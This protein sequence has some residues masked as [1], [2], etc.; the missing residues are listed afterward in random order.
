MAALRTLLARG[1]GV[2]AADLREDRRLRYLLVGATL[3]C[4]FW[5]WHR[6]PN[7][8]TRDEHSRLLDV[9][10]AYG[11]VAADPSVESLQQGVAWGRV[12]FGATFYLFGLAVLPV[13][14]LAVLLGQGELLTVFASP[15]PE[16]G[17]YPSWAATPG[18]FWTGALVVVR[19]VNVFLAVGC[20]YLTYRVGRVVW[21]R[22]AG[23]L[24]GLLLTLTF[25][26]LTIAHEGGEDM[27]ALC[28]VLLALY[29]LVRYVQAGARW[30]FLAASTAGGVAIAFKL[31]AAPVVALVLAAHVLRARQ[32]RDTWA[33]LARPALLLPGA[34]L[35]AVAIALGFP[36][37]LVGG[38]EEVVWRI[39]VNPGARATQPTGPDAAVWWWFLRGYLSGMSL[40]L[41]LGAVAGVVATLLRVRRREAAAGTVLVLTALVLWVGLFAGWHD[42]RV[43]HLLPTFPLLALLL[44][45]ALVRFH[46]SR[47]SLARPAVAVLLVTAGLY[48]AVGVGGYA[49]MPRDDAVAWLEANAE[50]GDTVEVYRRH[51]QDTAVPHGMDVNHLYGWEGAAEAVDRCPEFIQL[52]YRDLLYLDPG[53]Y[54]R[55]GDARASYIEGLVSE[56]YNYER[57]AEFGT[58]PPGFVPQRPTPGSVVDLLRHGVVPQTDQ[59]ADEQELAANQ[60]T[61][62]LERTGDCDGSR[63][64]DS[65]Y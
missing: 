48:A 37:L 65:P 36:T 39:V 8:A 54:Y 57:V 18:W 34:L 50:D 44:A 24:A 17:Y 60:Y 43:H 58:R 27:P 16:F 45:G 53:T 26:F 61:L 23:Q 19:L 64:R 63:L 47:P 14:L 22:T 42:F 30:R 10:V 12:P 41:F 25:G 1:V 21:S 2:V 52:G 4:G 40:P 46:G 59:Y 38:V 11:S 35:G 62:V 5:F 32:A 51:I 49:A 31:T 13:V 9:L 15:D 33:A 6:V 28:F 55:N 56:E 29:L 20:V 3:L 7:F